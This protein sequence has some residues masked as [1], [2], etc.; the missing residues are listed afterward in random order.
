MIVRFIIYG[1]VI[2][3]LLY[4]MMYKGEE[5][6]QNK[7]LEQIEL[8]VKNINDGGDSWSFTEKVFAG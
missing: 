6:Q 1:V 5:K 4:L 7:K 3:L 2:L 8:D